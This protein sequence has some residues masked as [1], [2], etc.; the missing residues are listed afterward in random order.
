MRRA[1]VRDEETS[2]LT[3]MAPAPLA[4]SSYRCRR[5]ERKAKQL[6]RPRSH[7]HRGERPGPLNPA[8]RARTSSV[9]PATFCCRAPVR[10]ANAACDPPAWQPRATAWRSRPPRRNGPPAP[11]RSAA[12]AGSRAQ[13]RARAA[14]GSGGC[15][16]KSSRLRQPVSCEA[17]THLPLLQAPFFHVFSKPYSTGHS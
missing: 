3:C 16:S 8:L 1:Y 9:R 14:P 7:C 17:P 4:P 10:V 11:R 13:P 6:A 12:G 15:S 2:T 5:Q